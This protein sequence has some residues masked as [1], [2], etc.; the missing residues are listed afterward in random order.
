[1]SSSFITI[2]MNEWILTRFFILFPILSVILFALLA[3]FHSGESKWS[4]LEN[5]SF[6]YLPYR[7]SIFSIIFFVYFCLFLQ[8]VAHTA[9]SRWRSTSFNWM[10]CTMNILIIILITMCVINFA[11]SGDLW[12][13]KLHSY[14]FKIIIK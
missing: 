4:S 3:E 12:R 10:Q 13:N 14:T 8:I 6:C 2:I 11:R 9:R 5:L 1:M 7:A